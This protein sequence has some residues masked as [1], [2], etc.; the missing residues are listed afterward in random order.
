MILITGANGQL[1][2][3][4]AKC[5]DKSNTIFADRETLDITNR[6]AVINF[7][8]ERNIDTIINCAAY[9]AVDKA[10]SEPELAQKINVDGPQNLALTGVKLI[11][12]STDY[13]FDGKNNVPYTTTDKTNPVSVYGKTKRDGEIAVENSSKTYAI[14]RTQWLYSE[15]GKNFA[16]TMQNLGSTKDSLNVVS[17]Q[18]GT[19]T[20]AGDLAMA[21][22]KIIPQL[23]PET[24]GIY[25]FSNEGVCSWYDFAHEIM[26]MKNLKCKVNPIPT[27]EYPTPATRPHYSVL[28]KSKIKQVFNIQ[29]NHWKES[30]KQCIQNQY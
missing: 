21:I 3:C 23:T 24:S 7:V 12:I 13:V 27:T 15:F 14:I 19:P 1:G 25:H 20:Y 10:E 11:H 9:T 17:D 18:V 5:I 28:D 8:R 6:D 30:L 4:L 16:K 29:I 2:Q 22:A 26:D